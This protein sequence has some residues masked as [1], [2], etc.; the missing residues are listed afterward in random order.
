LAQVNRRC[1]THV[2]GGF[3]CTPA[4]SLPDFTPDSRPPGLS[5]ISH[6][7]TR[8]RCGIAVIYV[9]AFRLASPVALTSDRYCRQDPPERERPF[10]KGKL[11]AWD[12]CD[13]CVI[14]TVW[15]IRTML[16]EFGEKFL[17]WGSLRPSSLSCTVLIR[18]KN[19]WTAWPLRM[20][21]VGCSEMSESYRC[22]TS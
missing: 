11:E 6:A 1:V 22:R 12:H 9:T 10:L 15:S 8:F 18:Q 4:V 14:S 7:F 21:L 2:C 16:M 3:V 17:Q 19:S 20:G 13:I 5:C